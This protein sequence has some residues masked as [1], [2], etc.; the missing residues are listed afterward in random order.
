MNSSPVKAQVNAPAVQAGFPSRE[1]KPLRPTNPEGSEAGAPRKLRSRR[2][3]VRANQLNREN[4]GRENQGRE[5][6]GQQSPSSE[7]GFVSQANQP[8]AVIGMAGKFPMAN[9]LDAFWHNIAQGKDC[10][11][12]VPGDRWSISDYYRQGEAT[13][14]KTNSKWMGTLTEHDLFD[15]LFFN[16]SPIEA[17]NMD[18]QQRVFLQACWHS[19]EDAGYNP[20]V[21]SGS[22]CGVFVGC[23]TN[24]Y[25]KFSQEMG[26][27]ISIL[28]AR[29][30]YFLNLQGPCLSIDTACS[31]SLV[32]IANACDSLNLGSSDIALAGG[33][34]IMVGPEMHIANS[35]TGMLST[36]GRCFTFDKR[37]NGFVPGEGVGVVMLKRLEDAE[38]DQ[39]MI[40]A[41]IKGWGVNQDGKTN[42]IT[43]PNPKSQTRLQQEV[44]QKF[45]IDPGHIQL[46]EAH[47]TGTKLGDP[48]EVDGLK[49]SF[50]GYTRDT[51]F[52]ALGSVKSN[53][54]HCLFAAGISGVI[55]LILSIKHKQL[56]PAANYRDL[57]E[58][59][60]LEQ[61]PFYVNT[62]LRD[63]T[64]KPGVETRMGAINSFGFSGTNAHLVL[65][66]HKA[67]VTGKSL[68]I[69][70]PGKVIIP[71]SAKTREQ[72]QQKAADL[73][74]FV[75]ELQAGPELD[76]LAWSLQCGRE[77][78]DF[79]LSFQ[80]ESLAELI[81]KLNA[82][83]GDIG[84]AGYLQDNGLHFS[85]A[86]QGYSAADEALAT[87]PEQMMAFWVQGGN[88]D[89]PGLYG[90]DMP[91]RMRLPLY[92]FARERYWLEAPVT[93]ETPV[94]AASGDVDGI[95]D[96][97]N[98]IHDDIMD[99]S[100]AV[101][102]LREMVD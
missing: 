20:K 87:S 19:I 24:E 27:S 58:H 51:G 13:P 96:I 67:A 41:V 29:I 81:A 47:G 7:T 25:H 68:A 4:Q 78:M 89:W 10:I 73:L 74:G 85:R 2:H 44:Y 100:D 3:Q 5:N 17:E 40:H 21:L 60:Q 9:D 66:E 70:K 38:R 1:L 93:V 92:P 77:A 55:K 64:L 91:R 26:G 22:R 59:I 86:T 54:G 34:N 65:A 52:C 32:A 94:V 30:S 62:R 61:S 84:S 36:D 6:L 46:V 43:A 15:P 14:G 99:T 37:A 83:Q 35:Q 31:S 90:A 12:E 42:G 23:G 8:V 76:S 39:D 82:C 48:I 49:H 56:A 80:V 102:M 63:W 88:V 28:A 97:I 75:R 72:L 71:L 101:K 50:A 95:E 16:I 18:P 69:K 45:N 79:R 33:V 11:E 53:I 57:N 98:R